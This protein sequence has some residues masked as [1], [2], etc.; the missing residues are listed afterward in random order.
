MLK[1]DKTVN[2]HIGRK[3]LYEGT[4]LNEAR[5]A[6]VLL[7]GRGAT[8][9]SMQDLADEI[10]TE[11]LAFIIPQAENFSWYPFPFIENREKNEPDLSSALVLVDSLINA[12]VENGINK[13]NI[14]LLGF[15]QGACLAADYVARHSA[16]YGGVFILSGGL[17]GREL[18]NDEYDG[19][20]QQTPVFLGCSDF[21][22]H[23]PENRVHESAE[24]FDKLNAKVTKKIYP[25]MGHTINQDEMNHINKMLSY[26]SKISTSL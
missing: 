3:I 22:F 26:N 4:P 8:A 23:I 18:E 5:A 25:G 11:N 17:I 6:M 16:K 19:N 21:D 10:N 9:Q 1:L 2:P 13:D 20:L 15:S 12:V 7:H 24:I 14:F